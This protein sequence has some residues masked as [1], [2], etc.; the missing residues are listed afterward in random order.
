MENTVKK[1]PLNVFKCGPIKAAIWS[2]SRIVNDSLVDIPSIRIDKS[3]K[4]KDGNEWKYTN[5]FNVEDLPNVA[6]LAMEVYKFLKVKI[7]ENNNVSE[8]NDI[9]NKKSK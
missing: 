7:S 6:V 3:Y 8:Q 1:S 2:D 9:Q 5:T 4:D